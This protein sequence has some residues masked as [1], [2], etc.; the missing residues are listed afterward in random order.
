[1]E[2]V[3]G[4]EEGFNQLGED[5]RNDGAGF[6][7]EGFGCDPEGGFIDGDAFC[8]GG[9]GVCGIDGLEDV[10]S[11]LGGV[12]VVCALEYDS[13]EF[14]FLNLNAEGDIFVDKDDITF[15]VYA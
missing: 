8:C 11:L 15:G 4:L 6:R 12:G 5:M 1:V 7:A 13:A 3:D 10:F 9:F 14:G 2:E